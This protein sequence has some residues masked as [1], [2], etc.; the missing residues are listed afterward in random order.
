MTG[1]T[2]VRSYATVTELHLLWGSMTRPTCAVA[3][4]TSLLA[5]SLPAAS[6][7]AQ[8]RLYDP[9]IY[10]TD[11][12]VGEIYGVIQKAL[13]PDSRI[14]SVDD[15]REIVALGTLSA[16]AEKCGLPWETRIFL[17]MMARFR[18]E[19]KLPE[20]PLT[21]IGMLHGVQQGLVSNVLP[22]H[23]C[24]PSVKASLGRRMTN[25]YMP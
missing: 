17:P 20:K 11:A 13:G 8:E 9:K 5:I 19:R 15:A 3:L 2:A 18:H 12:Q 25:T 6:A 14:L 21:L 24:P 16:I 10:V 22:E 23:D 4:A 7:A 1:W